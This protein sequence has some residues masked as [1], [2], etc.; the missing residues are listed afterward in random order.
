MTSAVISA[1]MACGVSSAIQSKSSAPSTSTIHT[2]VSSYL[3]DILTHASFALLN[4]SNPFLPFNPL[5]LLGPLTNYAYL[6]FFSGDKENEASQE[7]RYRT[8]DPTK[9]AQL[10]QYRREKNSVWPAIGEVA[11]PWTW[12]VLAGGVVG[13]VGEKVAR[14]YCG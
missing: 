2:N 8:H 12:V 3:G 7:E 10:Q 5:V 13:V 9:Y 4:A 1:A 11:N 14:H 6:R